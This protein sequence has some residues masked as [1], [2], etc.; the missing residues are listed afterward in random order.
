MNDIEIR[1]LTLSDI[2]QLIILEK[3]QWTG[4]QLPTEEQLAQRINAYPEL[5][6]G[7]FCKQSGTALASLFLKPVDAKDFS[8]P[9]NWQDCVE[10]KQNTRRKNL[11]KTLFGISFT[12]INAFAADLIFAYGYGYFLKRGCHSIILGSPIPGYKKAYEREGMEVEDY[13]NRK[14]PFKQ[15]LP[16]DPQLRYY[17]SRGFRH[18]VSIQKDY[19]PH[20]DSC[21]YGVIL[22][23][24]V[25][26]RELSFI[27]RLLPE[28][29]IRACCQQA[30]VFLHQFGGKKS[31][32]YVNLSEA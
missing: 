30:V 32:R 13:V 1:H 8:Q 16:Y 15:S 9:I 28:S 31:K 12:S 6:L 3:K 11:F 29:W 4:E 23:G 7:A 5:C 2:N 26:L 18:I 21:D 24:R 19:F 27:W 20:E 17:R 25:P 14:H 10:I 22:E